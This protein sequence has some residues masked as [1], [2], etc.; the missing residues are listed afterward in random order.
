MKF[1]TSNRFAIRGVVESKQGGRTENQDDMGFAETPLGFLLVVCDGMGGGPGGKTASSLVVQMFLHCMSTCSEQMDSQE[2]MKM[3]IGK[4]NEMLYAKMDEVPSLQG[5]GTTLVALLINNQ[6]ALIAHLGDSRCYQ[7]RGNKTV[8]RT[9]D[10]S[11][12][13]ELVQTKVLTEEQARVSP[14]SNLIKRALG[15]TDNHVPEMKEISF[16]KGD[17]FVL[18]SD[19]VWGIMPNKDLVDRLTAKQGIDSIVS[20]LSA[21]IDQIGFSHGGGHDNH[22]LMMIE[23]G[24][25]SK[26]EVKMNKRAKTTIGLMSV[27]LL[28]S[29]IIN[30]VSIGK[31]NLLSTENKELKRQLHAISDSQN[32]Y[33][34]LTTGDGDEKLNELKKLWIAID[35]KDAE[36]DSLKDVLRRTGNLNEFNDADPDQIIDHILKLCDDFRESKGDS[37]TD[38]AKKKEKSVKDIERLLETF[39]SNTNKK[40]NAYV[41]KIQERL[42][43][44]GITYVFKDDRGNYISTEKAKEKIEKVKEQIKELKKIINE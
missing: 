30:G 20:N 16:S 7:L 42:N 6:S 39:D 11:L 12:V 33:R 22:T 19:G 14:Q 13:S 28:V 4:A 9:T 44:K 23:M 37:Q 3:A 21:E 38:A 18:C 29:L 36:I 40:Y 32:D 17:R 24:F 27:L 43:D 5:M 8:F 2:A 35:E 31:T 15:N 25:D 26:L 1:I 41:K 10:H 34:N